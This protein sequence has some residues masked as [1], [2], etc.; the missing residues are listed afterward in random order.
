MEFIV[1]CDFGDSFKVEAD[2]CLYNGCLVFKM[3]NSENPIA[4]FPPGSWIRVY[5]NN[6]S[7]K[8]IETR[9][10]KENPEDYCSDEQPEGV[11]DTNADATHLVS[12]EEKEVLGWQRLHNRRPL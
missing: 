9:L 10:D 3:D 2:C 7:V 5:R 4:V 11:K 8:P 6:G 1:D 12:A